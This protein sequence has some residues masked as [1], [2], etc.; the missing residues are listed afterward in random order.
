MG[1]QLAK[2]PLSDRKVKSSLAPGRYYDGGRNGLHLHVRESGSKAWVQRIRL[3]GKY[4]DLGLGGYPALSLSAA[5][6]TALENKSLT[7]EGK[8]PRVAKT[9]LKKVP[10]FTE[11]ADIVVALKTAAHTNAKHR[12]QWASTIDTYAKPLLGNIPVDQIEVEHILG[13]LEPIWITKHETAS[14]L[15]GRLEAIFDYAIARKQRSAPNPATWKA[16]LAVLLSENNNKITKINQPALQINDARRWWANLSERDGMG[17]KALQFLALTASR[18][19]EVRG[20]CWAEIDFLKEDKNR[21][22][23][24]VPAKRMKAKREHRIPLTP[25]MM[26]ILESLPRHISSDLVFHT[27]KGVALSDMTLNATM[28]RIHE[29]DLNKGGNGFIDFTTKK[30]AVPHGIRST[31]RNWA[32]EGGYDRDMAEIQLAHGIGDGTFHAYHRTD[33]VEKRHQMMVEWG[34]FFAGNIKNA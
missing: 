1:T 32:A 17:T 25:Q 20:M 27:G 34:D 33:L 2:Q 13:I 4:V 21:P 19:G 28:K 5:R 8:D 12:A 23:W 30:R 9:T 3:Q 18:S 15:R 29:A 11:V 24:I 6:K 26:S 7:A 14:R 31:F 16:N 22:I 10:T